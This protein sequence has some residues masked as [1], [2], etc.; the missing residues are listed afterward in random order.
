MD[1]EK[2]YSK[3][4]TAVREHLSDFEF[5]NEHFQRGVGFS[6]DAVIDRLTAYIMV[7]FDEINDSEIAQEVEDKFEDAG[8]DND[9]A[10]EYL[11]DLQRKLEEYAE[12]HNWNEIPDITADQ[13]IC[14]DIIQKTKYVD[15]SNDLESFLNDYFPK[16][17]QKSKN[18]DEL[19]DSISNF[20]FA[21]FSFDA[22]LSDP[23]QAL[24]QLYT[25]DSVDDFIEDFEDYIID[26]IEVIEDD[27]AEWLIDNDENYLN[28]TPNDAIQKF[29][30]KPDWELYMKYIKSEQQGFETLTWAVPWTDEFYYSKED[31]IRALSY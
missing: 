16:E 14:E 31:L 2:I 10:Y 27:F 15:Y 29:M 28:M 5:D 12:N 24:E 6:V 25:Y 17:C 20:Q 1:T 3:V 8:W 30:E 23:G 18:V 22:N 9:I 11:Y 13:T 7:N 26:N 21:F 4:E 19:V